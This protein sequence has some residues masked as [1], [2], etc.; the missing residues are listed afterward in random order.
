MKLEITPGPW[1]LVDE[2]GFWRDG[3]PNDTRVCDVVADFLPSLDH[4]IAERVRVRDAVLIAAAPQLLEF[5]RGHLY[6]LE[7]SLASLQEN[8][9]PEAVAF[10]EAKIAAINAVL[11][12]IEGETP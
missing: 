4:T 6:L 10:C 2:R 9:A 1:R 8:G 11:S 7:I 12:K 5:T 3:L